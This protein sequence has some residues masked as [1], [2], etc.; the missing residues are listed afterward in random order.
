V[1]Y[2]QYRNG[3]RWLLE[4]AA[5][6]KTTRFVTIEVEKAVLLRALESN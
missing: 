1:G 3:P 2:S 6:K 5:K 4:E